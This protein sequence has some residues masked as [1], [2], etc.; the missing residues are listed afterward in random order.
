MFKGSSAGA[1]SG[2][3]HVYRATRRRE[4]NRLKYIEDQAKKVRISKNRGRIQKNC[5]QIFPNQFW[6]DWISFLGTW[7]Q[8]WLTNKHP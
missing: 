1:G 4:N 3:F 2:E 6:F 7:T 5:S 8:K